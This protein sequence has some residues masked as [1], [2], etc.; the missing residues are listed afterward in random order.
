MKSK[1]PTEGAPVANKTR[2]KKRANKD[3]KREAEKAKMYSPSAHTDV[4]ATGPSPTGDDQ[5]N[6][7]AESAGAKMI[8]VNM[9]SDLNSEIK[10]PRWEQR[11]QD[12]YQIQHLERRV[13]ELNAMVK[14]A[15]D[16]AR[17]QKAIAEALSRSIRAYEGRPTLVGT[18]EYADRKRAWKKSNW[19]YTAQIKKNDKVFRASGYTTPEKALLAAQEQA[20]AYAAAHQYH[21][22]A[23]R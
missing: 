5:P 12:Y 7:C 14:R 22:G 23:D 18:Y 13:D 11:P 15:Q 4:F 10:P 17:E 1:F 2:T 6:G 19:K 8:N 20:D 3:R 9:G 21:G 16:D